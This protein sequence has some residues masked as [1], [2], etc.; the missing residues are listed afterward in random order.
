MVPVHK[1][2]LSL[3]EIQTYQQITPISLL[4]YWELL[5]V[6][7]LVN[8]SFALYAAWKAFMEAECSERIGEHKGN[9]S[10]VTLVSSM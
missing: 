4:S 2:T 7:L 8:M 9:K 1:F 5:L 6:K 10:A 3:E